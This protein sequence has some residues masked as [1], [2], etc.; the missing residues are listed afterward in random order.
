MNLVV[1]MASVTEKQRLYEVL[2]KLKPARYIFDIKQYRLRRS[3]NQN[4]YYFGVVLE[5]ISQAT[6]F[7][8]D[9]LHDIL[10]RKFNP[11]I[12]VLRQTG[13]EMVIGGTTTEMNTEE[14]EKYLENIRIWALSEL[15]CLVPLPNEV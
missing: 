8:P 13:E 10:K 9:E 5:R 11:K 12:K 6:G 14:F 7:F 1:D 4:K 15:D 2:K 3:I